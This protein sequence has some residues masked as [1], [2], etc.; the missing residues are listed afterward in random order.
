MEYIKSLVAI[1]IAR[2]NADD[3]LQFDD[4]VDIYDELDDII[5]ASTD[6]TLKNLWSALYRGMYAVKGVMAEVIPELT[7]LVDY[8]ATI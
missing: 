6:T 7:N 8:V 1:I 4:I 2:C 5:T 3:E